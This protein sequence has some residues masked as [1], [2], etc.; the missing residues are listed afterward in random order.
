MEIEPRAFIGLTRKRLLRIYPKGSRIGSSNY[1]PVLYWAGG[2]Q[3]V[4]LNTQYAGPETDLNEAM[5]RDNGCAGYVLKPHF[6]IDRAPLSF[7]LFSTQSIQ[8]E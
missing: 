4:A 5:F 6:L 2:A 1:N 7:L 8:Y 3:I